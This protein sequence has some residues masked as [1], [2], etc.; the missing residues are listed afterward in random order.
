MVDLDDWFYK[1]THPISE[2]RWFI[3]KLRNRVKTYKDFKSGDVVVWDPPYSQW[4]KDQTEENLQKWY[5]K[6]GYGKDKRPTFVYLSPINDCSDGFRHNSGHCVLLNME[7]G[8]LEYMRHP[9]DF[10]FATDEE[11]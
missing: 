10:R 2:I 3:F 1:L 5:G 8:S 4:M 6:L 11:F 9:E 7:D